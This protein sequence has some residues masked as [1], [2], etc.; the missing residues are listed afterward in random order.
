MGI[1]YNKIYE[2]AMRRDGAL[3]L[4]LSFALLVVWEFEDNWVFGVH[5]DLRF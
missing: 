1:E 2:D 5:W 4:S 3:S